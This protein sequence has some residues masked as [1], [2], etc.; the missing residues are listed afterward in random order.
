VRASSHIG[1]GEL[2]LALAWTIVA[3]PACGGG[4]GEY[5]ESCA[6]TSDCREE[7]QCLDR[8]CVDRCQ[9]HVDCGDGYR[10][11]RGGE[12][13]LVSSAVGDRCYREIECG[14]AQACALDDEDDDRDGTLAGTCQIQHPGLPTSA[15]CDADEACQIGICSLGRC[16]QLCNLTSDCPPGLT[17]ALVPRLLPDSAPRFSAC[18]PGR[19]VIADELPFVGPTGTLRVPVPSHALSFALV[20]R[21][22]D[23]DQLVGVSR[24]V[25]PDG[26][27][28]YA[29]PSQPAEFY[30]NPI[31]YQPGLSVSTLFVSNTPTVD[32]QFGVYEVTVSSQ[33]EAGGPGT[34]LPRVRALYKVDSGA[35]L[36]LH[37]H[38]LDLA[39]H[40]CVAAFERARLDA[41]AA[42]ASD[43]FAA[44]VADIDAVFA[45]AGIHVGDVTY[46]DI[47]DRE[48]LD[49]L[50]RDRAGDLFALADRAT[51]V[52]VFLV[53]SIAPAGVQVLVG[54]TPGPPRTPGTRASG[55]AIGVDTLCYRGWSE[56]ARIVAHGVGRQMGLYYNRDGEGNLDAIPDSDD[57][58]SNLMFFSD[59]G[60]TALSDGQR[61]VLRRY[62]G[63]R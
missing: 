8:I 49:G 51:G 27:L 3:L 57:L 32:L 31:R 60:G 44:F 1:A 59:L 12:C 30:E 58:S 23:R 41:S 63:L 61:E 20:T 38:F 10:C 5:G 55:I 50:D 6:E 39:E 13:A 29:P 56:L 34:A 19:G 2:A 24:V 45:S 40:P 43:V 33:L 48:D 14:P 25:A 62:P 15:E 46:R 11:E 28:L 4:D 22:D 7:L 35:T 18:L 36:D 26:R 37:F 47:T 42:P 9:T 21:T 53:R 54:G 52:N 17:C 16:T